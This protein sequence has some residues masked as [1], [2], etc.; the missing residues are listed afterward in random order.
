MISDEEK[1][2]YETDRLMWL[3]SPFDLD[4]MSEAL[5]FGLEFGLNVYKIFDLARQFSRDTATPFKELDIVCIVYEYV[6]QEARHRIYEVTGY[7]FI[8]D[9]PGE[10]Y[11]HTTFETTCYYCTEKARKHLLAELAALDHEKREEFLDDF[12]LRSLEYIRITQ[13]DIEKEAE[14]LQ[15]EIMMREW[16]AMEKRIFGLEKLTEEDIEVILV[17]G[18]IF[19]NAKF[20]KPN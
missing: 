11:T 18:D 7:N 17:T 14:A 6:R 15:D 8:D 19:A 5:E 12:L 1:L 20:Q 13:F 2:I 3:C 16:L 9:S 4:E 10:I